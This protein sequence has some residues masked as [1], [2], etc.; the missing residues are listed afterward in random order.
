MEAAKIEEV[1]IYIPSVIN[2]TLSFDKINSY[3][4]NGDLHLHLEEV[5]DTDSV[6][7]HTWN[8]GWIDVED[9]IGVLVLAAHRR[10]MS[11]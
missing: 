5:H 4:S 10:L 7:L 1:V 2:G 3:L 9:I 11:H 8:I 6:V